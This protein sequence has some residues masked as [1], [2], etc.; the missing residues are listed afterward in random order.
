[1]AT[2][3]IQHILSLL[4][5]D[6]SRLDD[7][8]HQR[9]LSIDA[10]T[11]STKLMPRL[12][13]TP[14]PPSASPNRSLRLSTAQEDHPA[15]ATGSPTDATATNE[16]ALTSPASDLANSPSRNLGIAFRRSERTLTPAAAA[17]RNHSF[18]SL[19]KAPVS[20]QYIDAEDS[21]KA[22]AAHGLR[23]QER[24]RN[25]EQQLIITRLLKTTATRKSGGSASS[26]EG[27][28]SRVLHMERGV[29]VRYAAEVFR[30]WSWWLLQLKVR[31]NKKAG[32]GL[33]EGATSETKPSGDELPVSSTRDSSHMD[34]GA[35]E[36]TRKVVSRGLQ[37]DI[38][39]AHDDE[40]FDPTVGSDEEGDA[41]RPRVFVTSSATR[42]RFAL[43]PTRSS[44]L[45][46]AAASTSAVSATRMTTS[47]EDTSSS[48]APPHESNRGF[49]SLSVAVGKRKSGGMVHFA[50]AT[51]PA[52]KQGPPDDVRPPAPQSATERLLRDDDDDDYC[53][54]NA[55]PVPSVVGNGAVGTSAT[56]TQALS[57]G[58]AHVSPPSRWTPTRQQRSPSSLS[59]LS[60]SAA[61]SHHQSFRRLSPPSP[62]PTRTTPP[63]RFQVT[64][65]HAALATASTRLGAESR[66]VTAAAL[67][68]LAQHDREG[69]LHMAVNDHREDP[70]QPPTGGVVAHRHHPYDLAAYPASGSAVTPRNR[71]NARHGGDQNVADNAATV[72]L[73]TPVP[74]DRLAFLSGQLQPPSSSSRRQREGHRT[75]K[76]AVEE[77]EEEDDCYLTRGAGSHA[78]SSNVRR[79]PTASP[80]Y[81]EIS[82]LPPNHVELAPPAM[83]ASS[84]SPRLPFTSSFDLP[85]APL[86]TVVGRDSNPPSPNFRPSQ[87][88]GSVWQRADAMEPRMQEP[89]TDADNHGSSSSGA[90]AT[91]PRRTTTQAAQNE[92]HRPFPPRASRSPARPVL[93][94]HPQR[95][96]TSQSYSDYS[97]SSWSGGPDGAGEGVAS[98]AGSA[99]SVAS[100]FFLHQALE[101]VRRYHTICQLRLQDE[102]R[103][104]RVTIAVDGLTSL[105]TWRSDCVTGAVHQWAVSHDGQRQQIFSSASTFSASPAFG[106][107]YYPAVR[108]GGQRSSS[109]SPRLSVEE[110]PPAPVG[111]ATSEL[112]GHGTPPRV[113]HR[114][115]VSPRHPSADTKRNVSPKFP[116]PA[117]G[118]MSPPPKR[119]STT[120]VDAGA[121]NGASAYP[122]HAFHSTVAVCHDPPSPMLPGAPPAALAET[123]SAHWQAVASDPLVASVVTTSIPLHAANHDDKPSCFQASAVSVIEFAVCHVDAHLMATAIPPTA[124]PRRRE[125]GVSL[126]ALTHVVGGGDGHPQEGG[127]DPATAS[128][129]VP[130]LPRQTIGS[131]WH[132]HVDL[133]T[134]AGRGSDLSLATTGEES[135]TRQPTHRSSAG[136][137]AATDGQPEGANVGVVKMAMAHG[138]SSS[139]AGRP[140]T[141]AVAPGAGV[142]APSDHRPS[143]S[144]TETRSDSRKVDHHASDV[145]GP[146]YRLGG[147]R[148]V[149]AL[150]S[151]AAAVDEV[152]EL[153][154]PLGDDDDDDIHPVPPVVGGDNGHPHDGG[155]DPAAAS[156][157]IPQ[158]PR[159]T[160][161][162][163]LLLATTGERGSHIQSTTNRSS[164]TT[165]AVTTAV[166]PPGSG[167]TAGAEVNALVDL[168][169]RRR[170]A[171]ICEWAEGLEAVLDAMIYDHE[172]I[173]AGH[174]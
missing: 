5:R 63:N 128:V 167:A 36:R 40:R 10:G 122:P 69:L 67:S 93:G 55:P 48:A 65:S 124:P 108:G 91:H 98:D 112:E 82:D 138:P 147:G 106:R 103:D 22:A 57:H 50:A 14:P 164:N 66:Y 145:I 30:R 174:R 107:P 83:P 169:S 117:A 150:Q 28:R 25:L 32:S 56:R 143:E 100:A 64:A 86:S 60:V 49:A 20:R 23:L 123:R 101:E 89:L 38:Q 43:G 142:M 126:A 92:A 29:I 125:E 41:S 47:T 4:N 159:Q 129:E 96:S 2:R 78:P 114:R 39:S 21:E 133:P 76:E 81:E 6:R 156:V 77:E 113:D 52:V 45:R 19:V 3:D 51:A 157:E 71:R 1:M 154:P 59:S 46:P 11:V 148:G 104:A 34:K 105:A 8:P 16:A 26:D 61:Y 87:G 70:R 130:Q 95:D 132:H 54:A 140:P 75:W 127:R 171:I 162:G 12:S 102:E 85:A 111:M 90:T 168:A 27:V 17:S 37:I 119:S 15:A 73:L 137:V 99:T 161:S 170:G 24:V 68:S 109:P 155:R 110:L 158:L 152:Y 146:S 31:N 72:F 35:K 9:P 44:P 97:S 53:A 144:T 62:S 120:H 74:A 131:S 42:R 136:N 88:A 7:L 115:D 173:A 149:A 84:A 116:H 153:S 134:A 141:R 80:E 163:G 33:Q 135:A 166:D 165:A 58:S 18:H 13:K 79:S 94:H 160:D 151:A 139:A 172:R 121:R 118:V